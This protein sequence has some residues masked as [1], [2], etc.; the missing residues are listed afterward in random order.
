MY[1]KTIKKLIYFGEGFL[2]ILDKYERMIKRDKNMMAN[3]DEK[4]IKKIKK[5]GIFTQS[6]KVLI[7]NY[8]DS[9]WDNFVN[10]KKRRGDRKSVV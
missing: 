4:Q 7:E 5:R 1:T 3:V 2:P 10:S 8:V 9:N 6:I